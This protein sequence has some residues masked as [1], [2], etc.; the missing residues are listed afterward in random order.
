[1]LGF[2][3]AGAVGLIVRFRRRRRGQVVRLEGLELDRVGARFGGGVDQRLGRFKRS[4]VVD[5]GFGDD[6]DGDD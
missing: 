6:E 2:L 5:A 4:V 3:A 1:M